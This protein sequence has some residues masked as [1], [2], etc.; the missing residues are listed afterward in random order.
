MN[1]DNNK[2]KP[3]RIK[4]KMPKPKKIDASKPINNIPPLIP[5][6][7]YSIKDEDLEPDVKEYIN[8]LLKEQ[9][10]AE[11]IEFQNKKL[12]QINSD[13]IKS[14]LSE[15]MNTF[16]ILGYDTKGE[17]VFVFKADSADQK[18]ALYEQFKSIFIKLMEQQQKEF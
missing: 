4:G 9:I 17:R 18:D 7:M 13:Q 1:E 15:Y 3:K 16:L 2:N 14:I 8:T 10:Q 5:G 12:K 11:T 6:K